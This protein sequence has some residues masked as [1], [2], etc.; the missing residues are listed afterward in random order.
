[1][2]LE[3]FDY[4]VK[5]KTKIYP[6]ERDKVVRY[7]LEEIFPEADWELEGEELRGES[8]SLETF[9]KILYDM[10]IRDTAREHLLR[11]VKNGECNFVI[12]KQ[13]TCNGKINFYIVTQPLGPVEVTFICDKIK[14]LIRELT[15]TGGKR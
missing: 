2:S 12:S 1:M 5:I 15:R 4:K 10:K 9:A 8:R 14:P 6:T 13:A 3:Y 11:K 7:C